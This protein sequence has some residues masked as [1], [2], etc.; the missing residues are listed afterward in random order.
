[1]L[2]TFIPDELNHIIVNVTDKTLFSSESENEE[3]N[4]CTIS[5]ANDTLK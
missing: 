5:E 2:I 1:M 3:R 4:N